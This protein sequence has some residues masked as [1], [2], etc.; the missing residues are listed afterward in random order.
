MT[1]TAE[2]A[3]LRHDIEQV[4]SAH[5]IPGVSAGVLA[6]DGT[7]HLQTLGVRD[8]GG[9]APVG[10]DTPFRAASVSKIV[11][12]SVLMR[13]SEAGDLDLD[14][15]VRTYLPTFRVRDPV[16]TECVTL[17]DLVTH[18]AGWVSNF[19]ERRPHDEFG[20]DALAAAVTD[21]AHA[22]QI[23]PPGRFYSYCNSGF[24][25][26]GRVIEVVT[27]TSFEDA[28][29]Q[30][31]LRPAGLTRTHFP[32][33]G[34]PP[35]G[36][37]LGHNGIPPEVARPWSRS[38]ARSP[39][40]GLVTTVRDLLGFARSLLDGS[41]LAPETVEAMWTPQAE[42]VGFA[43]SIGFGWNVDHLADGTSY[44]GHGGNSDG[45]VAV[46]SIVPGKRFAVAA[47]LNSTAFPPLGGMIQDWATELFLGTARPDVPVR[48]EIPKPD[49]TAYLGRYTD[50]VDR[51]DVVDSP[52]G[53]VLRPPANRQDLPATEVRFTGA[54]EGVTTIA[55]A[56]LVVRFLRDSSGAVSW[57]RITGLVFRREDFR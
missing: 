57:L 11:T 35:P 18:R 49:V 46:L 54:D 44:V 16:V 5:A 51:V 21:L 52:T 17:R 39:S 27:G 31:V 38:R 29:D 41:V 43:E 7:E 55:G 28:A 37:A 50:G 34:S 23:S 12:A 42:A 14:L 9:R 1:S 47:L 2:L 45:Y 25:V 8:V 53:V 30:L 33:D 20:D 19:C 32:E 13:L 10:P 4:M 22:A 6:D 3:P 15:P 24:S 36:I 56:R 26:L 40:G 48:G